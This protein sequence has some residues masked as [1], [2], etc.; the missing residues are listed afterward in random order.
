MFGQQKKW[1]SAVAARPGSAAA[2]NGWRA[3]CRWSWWRGV[4][5]PR[6]AKPGQ[7]AAMQVT[8]ADLTI[9]FI[10]DERARELAGE[11][12]RWFDLTRTHKLVE[13][14]QKYNPGG[15]AL[16]KTCHELRPIPTNEILLSTGGIKQNPCY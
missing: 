6:A 8:A 10:L 15:A 1:R 9:D 2:T 7:A 3:D 5:A 14:V 13:R 12:T 16:V 4:S 11:T